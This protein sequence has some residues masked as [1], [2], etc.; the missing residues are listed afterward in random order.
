MLDARALARIL[1]DSPRKQQQVWE[2]LSITLSLSPKADVIP[3]F[4]DWEY[5]R[6]S[7]IGI[8]R[9]EFRDKL[10][11]LTD[12]ILLPD[13][14]SC[15]WQTQQKRGEVK[16]RNRHYSNVSYPGKQ[17]N[18]LEVRHDTGEYQS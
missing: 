10:T 8:V 2:L 17:V 1:L 9:L 11:E 18:V 4:V 5:V 12:W 14:P 3:L 13:N 6:V 7:H 15:V 16:S